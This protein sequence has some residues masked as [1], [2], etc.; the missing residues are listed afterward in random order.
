[1][2]QKAV[3]TVTVAIGTTTYTSRLLSATV[4]QGGAVETDR[5]VAFGDA[6]PTFVPRPVKT[7]AEFR[8]AMLCPGEFDE[9]YSAVLGSVAS[10]TVTRSMHDGKASPTTVTYTRD[11]VVTQVEYGEADVDSDRKATVTITCQPHAPETVS[12][13]VQNAQESEE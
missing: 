12:T 5:I 2:P 6:E 9:F 11:M 1:M 8:F 4:G 7:P 3:H 10:V 13:P